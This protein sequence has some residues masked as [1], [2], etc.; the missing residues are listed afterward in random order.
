MKIRLFL[1]FIL[2]FIYPIS[3]FAETINSPEVE[4]ITIHLHEDEDSKDSNI[5]S[6]LDEKDKSEVDVENGST[7]FLE[8]DS[9]V[10]EEDIAVNTT[11]VEEISEGNVTEIHTTINDEVSTNDTTNEIKDI[12]LTSDEMFLIAVNENSA[13]KKLELFIEG[14]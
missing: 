9:T 3:T 1:P 6:S 13:S 11:S 8:I 12:H 7:Q 2:L 14:Y 5:E 10:L 4:K